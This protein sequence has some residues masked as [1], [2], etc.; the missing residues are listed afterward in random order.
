MLYQNKHLL[1]IKILAIC[2]KLTVLPMCLNTISVQYFISSPNY[3]SKTIR[4]QNIQRLPKRV[5]F[6]TH[7]TYKNHDNI[8]PIVVISQ[9]CIFMHTMNK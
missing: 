5:I 2:E 6:M 7:C 4:R 9:N 3:C 8:L 1:I